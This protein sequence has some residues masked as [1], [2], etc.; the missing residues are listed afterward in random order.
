MNAEP[1][2][3]EDEAQEH[4]P[5]LAAA[6]SSAAASDGPSCQPQRPLHHP[7]PEHQTSVHDGPVSHPL[8]SM[9]IH[10]SPPGSV[11]ELDQSE[12]SHVMIVQPDGMVCDSSGATAPADGKCCDAD[13]RIH[14]AHFSRVPGSGSAPARK[15]VWLP[16]V[17]TGMPAQ[18]VARR[19]SSHTLPASRTCSRNQ[20]ASHQHENSDLGNALSAAP[21]SGQ[22]G[23]KQMPQCHV[24]PNNTSMDVEGASHAASAPACEVPIGTTDAY[25]NDKHEDRSEMHSAGNGAVR[26]K[27]YT[28]LLDKPASSAQSM[29]RQDLPGQVS[30]R[31]N[32][33]LA[34]EAISD[35]AS[36]PFQAEL[37]ASETEKR[38]K[39]G[40]HHAEE[41]KPWWVV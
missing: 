6:F 11:S 28:Q 18:T 29:A 35:R 15:D 40:R 31:S 20:S 22:L 37:S 41:T 4:G 38:R 8:Q 1:V 13:G 34:S 17:L 12:P 21:N 7:A 10:D 36:S 32:D 9:V 30:K 25:C 27:K 23:R 3:M 26:L 24:Q 33:R 19:A 2:A 5:L 16:L 14:P 39:S